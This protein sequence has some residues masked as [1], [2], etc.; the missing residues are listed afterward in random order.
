MRAHGLIASGLPNKFMCWI[1][2]HKVTRLGDGDLG[3][4]LGHDGIGTHTQDLE[5]SPPRDRACPFCHMGTQP[6]GGV[7]NQGVDPY[8]ALNPRWCD[9][10]LSSL[11]KYEK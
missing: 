11:W 9:L 4:C 7:L 10:K 6:K 8:Q 3:K 2:T 5:K 1:L